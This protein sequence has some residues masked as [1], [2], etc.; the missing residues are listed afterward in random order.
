MKR[1]NWTQVGVFAAVVLLVFLVGV[2]LL[3]NVGGYGGMMGPGMMSGWGIAPFGWLGMIF[4]WLVPLS[5]VALLV[6]GIVWL[7]RAGNDTSRTPSETGS[8]P[9]CGRPTQTDWQY[10]PYCKQ[11]LV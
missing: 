2:S 1:I 8:C 9:D 5:F 7:L 4:M 6:A 3:G 10:C 11:K